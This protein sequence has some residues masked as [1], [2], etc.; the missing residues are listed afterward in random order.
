ME[1]SI[2]VGRSYTN[3]TQTNALLCIRIFSLLVENL[4]VFVSLRCVS[5]FIGI[6]ELLL[7]DGNF[8]LFY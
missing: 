8:Q 6:S 7:F 3:L 5:N 1:I 2:G 4:I